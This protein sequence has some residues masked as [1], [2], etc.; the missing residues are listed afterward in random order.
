MA[1]WQG[2]WRLVAAVLLAVIF[3]T[4]VPRMALAA[5]DAQS[6]AARLGRGINV[7]GYDP[8]WWKPAKARFQERHFA[9]IRAA[10][11]QTIRVNLIAFKHMDAADQ[12]DPRWLQTLD[13]VVQGALDQGLNVILDEHDF[14][15]CSKDAATCR[16]RLASFWRQVA[17]R[18]RRTD[19]RVLFEIL[20]EPHGAVTVDV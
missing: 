17:T 12:L 6:V 1:R 7:L 15:A 4:N 20:N 16:T 11:F 19:N 5:D 2:G 18:Y 10:G 9:A 13:W 8:I 3:S 14:D